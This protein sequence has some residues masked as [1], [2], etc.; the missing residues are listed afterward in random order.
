MKSSSIIQKP[1][2]TWITKE[3]G[4]NTVVVDKN[5]PLDEG[6]SKPGPVG[7]KNTSDVVVLKA[8]SGNGADNG[9][10]PGGDGLHVGR[11]DVNGCVEGPFNH[12]SFGHVQTQGSF[13]PVI[14]TQ[15]RQIEDISFTGLCHDDKKKI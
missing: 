5:Q 13:C 4:A 9:L 10:Q 1:Q 6:V 7:D 12:E 14:D 8:A 11:T 2:P 15:V 3:A